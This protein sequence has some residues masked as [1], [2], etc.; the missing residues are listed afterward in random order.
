MY[1]VGL[2]AL[3]QHLR[4]HALDRYY[5]VWPSND[6]LTKCRGVNFHQTAILAFHPLTDFG[7]ALLL[8]AVGGHSVA[9]SAFALATIT[10]WV[11]E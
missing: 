8:P 7:R 6:A 1:F 9:W 3:N 10:G 5:Q 2:K 11:N 4:V